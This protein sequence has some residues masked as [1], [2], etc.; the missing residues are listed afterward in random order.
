MSAF[1]S[2][3]GPYPAP[4]YLSEE[5]GIV[6][7]AGSVLPD[8]CAKCARAEELTSKRER[9]R[10]VSDWLT[11]VYLVVAIGAHFWLHVSEL[12]IVVAIIAVFIVSVRSAA[13]TYSLCTRCRGRKNTLDWVRRFTLGMWVALMIAKLAGSRFWKSEEFVLT[14]IMYGLACVA[15]FIFSFVGRSRLLEAKRITPTMVTL[16][17]VHPEVEA[18]ILGGSQLS[19]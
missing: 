1:Q 5:G 10:W 2:A 6:V 12:L 19:S 17:G 18:R 7:A 15:P 8:F 11:L 9:F 13:I 4:P 3:N 16:A 14:L